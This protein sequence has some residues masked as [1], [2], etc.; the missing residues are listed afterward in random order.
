M[1]HDGKFFS[2]F[3]SSHKDLAKNAKVRYYH[4]Q[5]ATILYIVRQ[6]SLFVHEISI[7]ES[8]YRP[9]SYSVF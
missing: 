5:G 7:S 1:N 6:K 2:N 4:V 3:K 8:G 9:C